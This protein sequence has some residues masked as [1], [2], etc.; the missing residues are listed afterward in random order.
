[1]MTK[2]FKDYLPYLVEIEEPNEDKY[3]PNKEGFYM[4]HAD[5][6]EYEQKRYP[7]RALKWKSDIITTKQDYYQKL[8]D[9]TITK[10]T[11][12]PISDNQFSI[13]IGEW[14]GAEAYETAKAKEDMW[15]PL[16]EGWVEVNKAIHGLNADFYNPELDISI[17][18][19]KD[20]YYIYYGD[21]SKFVCIPIE[22]CTLEIVQKIIEQIKK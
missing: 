1:M 11:F 18:T 22:I 20:D 10:G 19:R 14:I 9:G 16:G 7:T 8:P 12:H 21:G 17:A 4:Y 3:P 6:V 15:L 13:V 2:L 5:M